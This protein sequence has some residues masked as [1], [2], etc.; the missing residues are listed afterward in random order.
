MLSLLFIFAS[1][2]L[3]AG[4]GYLGSI[5]IDG[6]T[7]MGNTPGSSSGECKPFFSPSHIM[8]YLLMNTFR[9]L[10]ADSHDQR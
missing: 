9:S 1:L 6:T 7:Y 5:T 10:V 2:R 4:H 3:V 8:Y